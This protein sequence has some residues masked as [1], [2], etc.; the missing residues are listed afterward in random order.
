MNYKIGDVVVVLDDVIKGKVIRIDTS[1]IHIET[2]DGFIM[3]FNDYELVKIY[4]EQSEISKTVVVPHHLSIKTEYK[5]KKKLTKMKSK[6]EGIP[7]MEVD[8]HIDKLIKSKRGMDNFD[9]LSLQMDTAKYKLEFAIK[10]RIPRIVF[11]HG[12]GEGVL[13]EELKY[14][15]NRYN[16]KITEA[17][18]QKYGLGATEV[19]VLQKN[20]N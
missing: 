10:K 1:K 7:P 19:Y 14:L 2:E 9:I 18:Y 3:Q 13:R 4:L 20:K 12:V 5:K 15:F 6:K 8:L 16:V 17:S 11:I